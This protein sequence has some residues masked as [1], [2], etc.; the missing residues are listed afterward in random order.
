MEICH[1]H[2]VFDIHQVQYVILLFFQLSKL[3][4]YF[5]ELFQSVELIKCQI[6]KVIV[7][8]ERERGLHRV[9]FFTKLTIHCNSARTGINS[10]VEVCTTTCTS[11]M[12]SGTCAKKVHSQHPSMISPH[13]TILKSEE[14]FCEISDGRGTQRPIILISIKQVTK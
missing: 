14:F 9:I 5:L 1:F 7:L 3:I 8:S 12:N 11:R 10:K 4:V 2:I 13:F 6:G